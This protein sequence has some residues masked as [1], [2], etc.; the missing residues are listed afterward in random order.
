[1][2]LK[3]SKTVVA[4]FLD[5][6][7]HQLATTIL[8]V[9]S[10]CSICLENSSGIQGQHSP[11]E[12]LTAFMKMSYSPKKLKLH[13]ICYVQEFHLTVLFRGNEKIPKMSQVV[14]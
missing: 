2:E 5:L 12:H 6:R 9:R 4:N 3:H 8:N 14:V 10:P 13:L 7:D 11:Q 1:M